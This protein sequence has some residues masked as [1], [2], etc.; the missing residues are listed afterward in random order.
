MVIH[1]VPEIDSLFQFINDNKRLLVLS[2]AGISVASGIPTY[3][4]EEGTWLRGD[5]IMHDDFMKKVLT[6]KRYWARS[7][8]GWNTI[9][10]AKPSQAHSALVALENAG[11]VESIITQNVD[12]LHQRSGSKNVIDLHGRVDVV[13]CLQCH[14]KTS[15]SELQPLLENLNPNLAN[16]VATVLPD[17]DADVNDYPMQDVQ[18]PFCERCGG[19]LKPDVVFFGGSIDKAVKSRAE[20]AFKRASALLVVGSSLQVYSGYHYCKAAYAAGMAI[21][22][23]NPGLTRADSI[24]T[25]QWRQDCGELLVAVCGRLGLRFP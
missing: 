10:V 8:V 9:G 16:F 17:G 20:N 22:S 7:I 2:G 23:I 24:I 1:A 6:R 19:V 5:P 3:R 25:H 18:E 12:G 11:Y 13:V 14:Q 15:R 21:G 4:D